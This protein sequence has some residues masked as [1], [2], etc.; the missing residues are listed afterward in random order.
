MATDR[1][2]LFGVQALKLGIIDAAQLTSACSG[3]AERGDIA[4]AAVLAERGWMT[5]ADRERIERRLAQD[6]GRNNG[7]ATATL[8]VVADVD[9]RNALRASDD[10]SV[11][12][13]PS[14]SSR[15][16]VGRV[17]ASCDM[18]SLLRSAVRS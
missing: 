5:A 4:L 18:R 14:R 8:G 17:P 7:D 1:D 3:W 11:R 9:A 10:S 15:M 12:S 2:L 16:V 13:V 6:L